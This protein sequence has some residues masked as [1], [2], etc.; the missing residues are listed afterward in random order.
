MS[1]R[2]LDR[3]QLIHS[4]KIMRI[5]RS[6]SYD[7]GFHFYTAIGSYTGETATSLDIF[8]LKLQVIDAA[9]VKFHFQRNDFQKWIEDTIGDEELAQR[10]SQRGELRQLAVED[11]RQELLEIVQTRIDELRR[12]HRRSLIHDHS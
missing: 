8:V 5:L 6:V 4:S 3:E 7:M 9:S 1:E 12:L 10:I 11:L 2:T